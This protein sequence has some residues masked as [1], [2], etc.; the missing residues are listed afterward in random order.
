MSLWH[1]TAGLA[2]GFAAVLLLPGDLAAQG[3]GVR[4]ERGVP[5][6]MRDGVV[7]KADVYRPDDPGPFPVLVMST[8][9]GKQGIKSDAYVKAGYIVVCQDARGRYASGGTFESFVRP[10]TH[11]AEDGYDTVEWAARLSGSNGKVGT[12]GASY[13]AFLQWRPL[14]TRQDILV[15]QTE[16]LA[17]ALEV[18]GNPEVEL[19]AASSA[20]DTDLYVR[21]IDVA[22][23]GLA[24][25][26]SMGMVRARYRQSLEKP[27]L[28]EPGRVTRFTIRMNP[29]A[30]RFLTGH[31]LRLDVTSSDF[32]NYDRNHNTAHDQ[33][34]DA[35]LAVAE[36]TVH[37][38]GK[39]ASKFVLPRMP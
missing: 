13:N 37:H 6:P 33:N 19:Y 30:N 32:P 21:L 27:A 20:P 5:V 39:Y 10:Q 31:R 8:P 35:T 12:F 25:D 26:V 22:P 18:T 1:K 9:Y 36:Q 17:E 2:L 7:L 38:G 34:A 3:K 28:L 29:T 11:D 23:D 14:A 16:P 4:V 24:R 15:Y